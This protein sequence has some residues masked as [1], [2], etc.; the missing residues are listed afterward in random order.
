MSVCV[1]KYGCSKSLQASPLI[2]PHTVDDHEGD[3]A[4]LPPGAAATHRSKMSVERRRALPERLVEPTPRSWPSTKRAEFPIE[5]CL[6]V[7]MGLTEALLLD[8][9]QLEIPAHDPL[10]EF[11]PIRPAEI[12]MPEGE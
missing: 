8:V 5:L 12:P 4:T 7:E 6:L 10:V 2:E 9:A 11:G 1:S 3:A